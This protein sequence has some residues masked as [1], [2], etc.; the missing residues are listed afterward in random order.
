M[1]K[2]GYAKRYHYMSSHQRAQERM[3]ITR[4]KRA[5]REWLDKQQLEQHIK[6]QHLAGIMQL[7][8]DY[9][10]DGFQYKKVV[11]PIGDFKTVYC[12]DK[13]FSF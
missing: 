12:G 6:D 9:Y 10:K 13:I 4:F 8:R 2:K 11:Y 7:A 1:K 5:A 3:A